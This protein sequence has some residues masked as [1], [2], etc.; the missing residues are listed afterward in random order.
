MPTS[1]FTGL[2]CV[3][4]SLMYMC[5]LHGLSLLMHCMSLKKLDTYQGS[6]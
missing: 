4:T 6:C 5:I 3:Q 2:G 1:L